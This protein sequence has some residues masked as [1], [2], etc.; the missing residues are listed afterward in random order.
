M[1][2]TEIV[3]FRSKRNLVPGAQVRV[4]PQKKDGTFRVGSTTYSFDACLP[5]SAMKNVKVLNKGV[6]DDCGSLF[7]LQD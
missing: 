3:Q 7:L 2:P 5:S 1:D 6:D 4:Y